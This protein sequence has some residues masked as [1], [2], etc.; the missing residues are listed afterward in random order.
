MKIRPRI[1]PDQ[2]N[3]NNRPDGT[4]Y[5]YESSQPGTNV[6]GIQQPLKRYLECPSCHKVY[7]VNAKRVGNYWAYALWCKKCN[8]DESPKTLNRMPVGT[9]VIVKPLEIHCPNCNQEWSFGDYQKVCPH[10]N[11]VTS[12][13]SAYSED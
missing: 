7:L 2:S 12:G 10:C 4:W 5:D 3:P 8:G 9:A 11:T 1:I 6:P 13:K